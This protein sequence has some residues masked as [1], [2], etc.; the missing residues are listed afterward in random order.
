MPLARRYWVDHMFK[1][2]RLSGTFTTDTESEE[3]YCQVFANKIFFAAAY[4]IEKKGGAYEPIDWFV[5]DY[6]APETLIS[7]G[8]LE[9]VGRN[10]KAAKIWNQV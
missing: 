4:P 8:A 9:Q 7:D 5:Q 3:R 1:P 6:G 2:N 10:S